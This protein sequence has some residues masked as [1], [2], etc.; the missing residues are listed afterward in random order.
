HASCTM[1][2]VL[3][4][5]APV[6]GHTQ[7]ASY[8]DKPIQ[9]VVPFGPGGVTDMLARIVAHELGERL[10]ASVVVE[11]RQG[12][13]GNIGAAYVARA[14]PDGYTLLVGP[15]STNAINPSLF[16]NLT[17]DPLKDFAPI[18]NLASVDNLLIAGPD[19]PEKTIKEL[20]ERK[21]EHPYR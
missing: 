18:S 7:A 16:K 1:L 19:I 13:G 12:A 4:I 10:N 6:A 9:L 20:V 5:L 14:K 17:F 2:A 11:N 21:G 8:P 3:G 15:A